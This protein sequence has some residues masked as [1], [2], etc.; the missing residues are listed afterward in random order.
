VTV[1]DIPV[2]FGVSW[3]LRK[4]QWKAIIGNRIGHC[5]FE[6]GILPRG[7]APA[8]ALALSAI[9]PEHQSDVCLVA[10]ASDAG[11][12]FMTVVIA[13][14]APTVFSEEIFDDVKKWKL[15]FEDAEKNTSIDRVYLPEDD[16]PLANVTPKPDHRRIIRYRSRELAVPSGIGAVRR[17]GYTFRL[18]AGMTAVLIVSV[19]LAVFWYNSRLADKKAEAVAKSQEYRTE[20]T[21]LDVEPILDH[22]IESLAEF[23]PMAP[24]WTL[25]S[26]GCVVDPSQPPRGLSVIESQSAYAYRLYRLAGGWNEYLAGRAAERVTSEFAGSV[27]R[28][29]S[30]VVLYVEVVRRERLVNEN[31]RPDLEIGTILDRLFVGKI[32]TGSGHGRTGGIQATTGLEL[33]AVLDRIKGA[34]LETVH[35]SRSVESAETELVVR[36]VRLRVE[37]IRIGARNDD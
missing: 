30:R 12:S 17:S 21:R 7:A 36:P 9:R 34:D 29:V 37:N 8:A 2:V 32:R 31:T 10:L 28:E 22:C 16:D 1:N 6:S 33:R 11:D 14:G 27:K 3:G 18:A 15:A 26:E 13:D 23:W 25:A 5:E 35:V 19:T 4:G 24:E 20:V